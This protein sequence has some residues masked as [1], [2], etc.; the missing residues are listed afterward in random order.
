MEVCPQLYEPRMGN[1]CK[2][3]LIYLKVHSC[4]HSFIHS[5]FNKYLLSILYVVSDTI[6]FT[7]DPIVGKMHVHSPKE[8]RTPPWKASQFISQVVGLVLDTLDES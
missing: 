5:L 2:R 6:L 3:N 8:V 7:K 1:N 4:I